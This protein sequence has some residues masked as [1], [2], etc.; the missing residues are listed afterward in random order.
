MTRES[1]REKMII[2]KP[3]MSANASAALAKDLFVRGPCISIHKL[4]VREREKEKER[5]RERKR[6]RGVNVASR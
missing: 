5:N 6:E 3:L 1:R 2:G 4:F